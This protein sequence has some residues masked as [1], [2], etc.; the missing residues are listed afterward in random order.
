MISLS[1]STS[2]LIL[3]GNSCKLSDAL[4]IIQN[5]KEKIA[6]ITDDKNKLIGTLTDGD[7]RRS[8]LVGKSLDSSAIESANKDFIYITQNVED[9]WNKVSSII[10]AKGIRQL[11]N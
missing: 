11:P 10:T 2:S 5:S 8:L 1:T 6:L 3:K 4:N 7:V 9:P